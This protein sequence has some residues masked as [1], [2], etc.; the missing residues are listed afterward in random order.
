MTVCD[1][2]AHGAQRGAR[3]HRNANL[4]PTVRCQL[5]PAVLCADRASTR[6]AR[7][8][9]LQG[10][11]ACKGWRRDGKAAARQHPVLRVTLTRWQ[12]CSPASRAT[13]YFNALR[14][15]LTPSPPVLRVTLTP[16]PARTA[17][18]APAAPARASA[19]CTIGVAQHLWRGCAACPRRSA[20]HPRESR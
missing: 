18:T 8:R 1:D 2:S 14:V 13:S 12:G 6:P 11:S 17:S 3:P 19:L 10:L 15:T 4:Q 20:A 16:S 5:K 9:D 7:A